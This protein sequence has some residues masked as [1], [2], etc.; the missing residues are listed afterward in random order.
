MELYTSRQAVIRSDVL[1]ALFYDRVRSCSG[2]LRKMLTRDGNSS[3][4]METL[5]K[6]ELN[7]TSVD[8]V[9]DSPEGTG[10]SPRV[11]PIL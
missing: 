4:G 9:T 7:I 6:P 2:A 8:Q 1:E 10:I 11:A 3:P 5:Q